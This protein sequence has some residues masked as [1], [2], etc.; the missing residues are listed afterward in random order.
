[1]IA[2]VAGAL[3]LLALVDGACA[4][5]RS[6]AGRTGLI[7][8]RSADRHAARRGGTLVAILLSPAMALTCIVVIID[9]ASTGPYL[10]AGKIMLAVYAPYAL[11]V[12]AALAVFAT[13]DWRKRYLA[14]AVILGPFTFIRPALVVIGG[15]TAIAATRN[16]AVAVTTVLAVIAVLTTEPGADRLWYAPRARS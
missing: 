14:S 13:L 1:V 2:I 7:D 4:G 12:L 16:I 10:R 8:H 5:F 6:S 15:L 9:P 3:L 11:A